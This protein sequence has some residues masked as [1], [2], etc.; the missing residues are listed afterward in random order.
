MH[1]LRLN[2]MVIFL[3]YTTVRNCTTGVP[4]TIV[5][6]AYNIVFCRPTHTNEKAVAHPALA[7]WVRWLGWLERMRSL[8]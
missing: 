7:V 8:V 2:H 1:V 3:V 6:N 5:S 4:F